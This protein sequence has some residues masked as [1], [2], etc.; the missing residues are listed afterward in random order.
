MY[1]TR[2][3]LGIELLTLYRVKCLGFLTA[4]DEAREQ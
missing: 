3:I 2:T 1:S 4:A